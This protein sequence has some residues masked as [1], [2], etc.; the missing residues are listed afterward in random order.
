MTRSIVFDSS[1]W[2]ELFNGGPLAGICK[3]T[4][5]A[6]TLVGVPTASIFEIYRKIAKTASEDA[7][8]S[9]I[10]FLKTFPILDL[11]IEVALTAADLAIVHKLAMAD[12]VMLAHA[13]C[14]G[15]SLITLDNDFSGISD[16]EILRKR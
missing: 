14:A 12:S 13:V 10:A 6:N 7:A 4:L 3:K 11:T 9:A 15:A 5:S 8:L 16:V 2:I 1:A